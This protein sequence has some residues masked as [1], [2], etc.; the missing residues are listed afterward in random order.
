MSLVAESLDRYKAE[1]VISISL[2]GRSA[3]AD[4]LIIATGTSQRHVGSMAGNIQRTL[5]SIGCKNVSVEG[6]KQ[7]DW[8]L[9]DVGDIIIHLFL[10]EIREFYNLEKIWSVPPKSIN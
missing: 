3:I 9:I 5:K 2:K 6:A 1:D 8:V 4:F 7:C 10:R